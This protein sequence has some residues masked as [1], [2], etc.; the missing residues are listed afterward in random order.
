MFFKSK[1][2]KFLFVFCKIFVINLYV[3]PNNKIK[4]N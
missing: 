3:V 2:N 4:D 1:L